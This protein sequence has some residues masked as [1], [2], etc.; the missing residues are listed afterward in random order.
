MDGQIGHMTRSNTARQHPSR[1]ELPRLF[2]L[3]GDGWHEG[4]VVSLHAWGVRVDSDIAPPVGSL[5]VL[6]PRPDATQGATWRLVVTVDRRRLPREEIER[7]PRAFSATWVRACAGADGLRVLAALAA[8]LEADPEGGGC[9]LIEPREA[10][11]V[12]RQAV[13]V[14]GT[15]G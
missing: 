10:D 5:L 1:A 11:D 7:A 4:V 13:L 12:L 8:E 9:R 2:F 3:Y 14:L 6:Q 15:V